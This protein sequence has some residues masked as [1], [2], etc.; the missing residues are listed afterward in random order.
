LYFQKQQFAMPQFLSKNKLPLFYGIALA[1]IVFLMKWLEY[2]FVIIDHALE[3]YIGAIALIFTALGIWLTLKLNK[4]KLQTVVVEKEVYVQKLE[5]DFVSD[6]SQLTKMGISKR[7]WEVL[8]L[9]S[10]GLS[11]QEIANQLYLSLNTVKTHGSNLFLKLDV[12]RR[13][14]AIEKGKRMGLIG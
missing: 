3:I 12:K 5:P 11:N 9:M 2:K 13:T 14:Q 6:E 4:P 1:A 8:S 7:E 10:Q